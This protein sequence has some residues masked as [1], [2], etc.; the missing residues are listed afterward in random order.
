[1][2]PSIVTQQIEQG[3]RDFLRAT[4]SISTPHFRNVMEDFLSENSLFK[5][6]F[7][8][9]SLPFQ[10]GN[11]G[12]DRFSSVQMKFP[13]YVHQE[14]AFNNLGASPPVSTIVATGTGSGKTECF[15]Y[16]ILHH[17]W[18]HRHERGIKAILIYPMNALA[19]DQPGAS[20]G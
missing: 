19:T 11:T 1:M 13:P 17:C 5:G 2:L 4:F 12:V 10:R 14:K 15:L 8:S 6:P 18:I 20:H 3:I 9:L 16:P 7:L